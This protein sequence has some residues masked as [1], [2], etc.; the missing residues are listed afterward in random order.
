MQQLIKKST[1]LPDEKI[2]TM[3]LPLGIDF[4]ILNFTALSVGTLDDVLQCTTYSV[5]SLWPCEI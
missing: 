5:S 4:H 3:I 2:G 1:N